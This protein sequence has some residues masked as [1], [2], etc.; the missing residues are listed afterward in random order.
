MTL[1]PADRAAGC[2]LGL[3]LGDALGFVVEGAPPSVAAAYVRTELR[4]GRAGGHGRPPYGPGQYSDDTQLAREL[5]LSILDAGR[6]DPDA[7]GRRIARLFAEG[8]AIGAGPGSRAAAERLGAGVSWHEAGTPPP[9]AGNGAAMRAGPLGTLYGTDLRRLVAVARDQ[10]LVTHR[11]PR[12]VAGAVAVAAAVAVAGRPGPVVPGA[13]L[14]EVGALVLPIDRTVAEAVATVEAWLPLAPA[15]AVAGL[16]T[17]SA[18]GEGDWRGVSPFVTPSVAWSLYAFLHAPS[19]Y[20]ETV[21]TA[22]EVGGDTDTMA[23]M[24]GA[25]SGA[26]LG[27][28][29]LPAPALARLTDGGGWGASELGQL[30]RQSAALAFAEG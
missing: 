5:L 16:A 27:P 29:A 8:R 12:A 4:A 14:A 28:S 9:Y 18:Q 20:L 2:L 13:L 21:C 19:D 23:A 26:H 15:Q 17:V 30:A 7:F 25:M 22:I 10:A 6:F 1:D 11:D 24:A 3:A